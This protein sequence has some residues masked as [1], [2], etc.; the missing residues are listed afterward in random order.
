[1]VI[2]V[3]IIFSKDAIQIFSI[4]FFRILKL[5]FLKK[6][7]NFTYFEKKQG[8]FLLDKNL[9]TCLYIIYI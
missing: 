5:F 2:D 7:V 4:F 8:F 6:K 9:F 1:M 3:T